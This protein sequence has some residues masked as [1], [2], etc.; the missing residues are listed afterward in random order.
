MLQCIL[1]RVMPAPVDP[2]DLASPPPAAAARP[3]TL[4]P[5]TTVAPR[6]PTSQSSLLQ[7]PIYMH[8]YR[9]M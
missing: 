4:P 5:S 1:A 2:Q 8:V 6:A 7:G 9:H 3:V